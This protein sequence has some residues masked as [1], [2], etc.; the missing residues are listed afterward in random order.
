MSL[1]SI[2]VRLS[3][4][5][6]DFDTDTKRAAN[7]AEKRAKEI[8]A[9]FK[10]LGKQIGIALG[11]AI[12]AAAAGTVYALNGAIQKMDETYNAAKKV[13]DSTENFSRLNYAAGLADVGMDQLVTTMG[14]LT[15]SQAAALDTTSEQAK[16]FEALGIKVVDTSGKLRGSTDVMLDFANKFAEMKGSPEA[17][18]AGF[19]L[20]GRS[21]QD[22]IPL[23]EQGSDEIR[24]LMMEAD[25]L[26]VTVSDKTGAA[27]DQF[28][29][30]LDK[31]Q[32][33][34]GGVWKEVAVGLLPNLDTAAQRLTT[35]AS[36]GDLAR[37][38]TTLL[39]AALNFG[40]GALERYNLAV[41]NLS[42][43]IE[44]LAGIA[45]GA[46]T[47]I[48]SGFAGLSG[49]LAGLP[50]G[51]AG[52]SD[53]FGQIKD[54]YKKQ[55]DDRQLRAA[56]MTRQQYNDNFM[57]QF[58][59]GIPGV[60]KSI[61]PELPF[62]FA[63]YGAKPSAATDPSKAVRDLMGA[64]SGGSKSGGKSKA[65][66]LTDEQKAAKALNEEYTRTAEGLRERLGLMGLE[67]EAAKMKWETEEGSFKALDPLRKAELIAQAALVDAKQLALDKAKEEADAQK[68]AEEGYLRAI[69]GIDRER[70]TLGMTNEQLEIY[71][72][73]KWAGVEGN[74]AFTDSITAEMKELQKVRKSMDLQVEA[75]DAVR[76][77][78]AN[79]IEDMANGV[80]PIDAFKDALDGL[81]Q[82]LQQMIAD[83]LME[84]FFGQKGSASTG[85]AGGGVW[86]MLGGLFGSFLGGGGGYSYSSAGVTGSE[87]ASA[88]EGFMGGGG[89]ARGGWTGPGGM[90]EV[91]GTV[92][93][94]EV[95]W[96]KGDV[97]RA[98]GVGAVESMRRG[99][100]GRGGVTINQTITVPA[101][102]SYDTAQQ[103]G[104]L[105]YAGAGRAARRNG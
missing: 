69:E 20:F 33:A 26:G 9:T 80:K 105:A 47:I 16:M 28:R 74:Q 84:K 51:L 59:V 64:P 96:S 88:F 19:A 71:N 102:T 98:G 65:A 89:W 97:A 7:I 39:S 86:D 31:L 18:A 56:G 95:V 23:L 8:D 36:D 94:G 27:A 2:L 57:Q 38:A 87:F 72:A 77:A 6:A 4:N 99:R 82:Q 67:T 43:D 68:A 40:V 73:L 83:N 37:N 66:E 49:G 50:G 3:M 58:N 93:R 25:A 54:A 11:T 30:Q 29:D 75:M 24:R 45:D 32:G 10:K 1:G 62:N 17:M 42:I 46:M 48:S 103:A 90:N 15:K 52:I 70:E 14:K 21:F 5:T 53:G 41:D 44:A 79:F 12:S 34:I 81:A 22:M 61:F 85:S 78:G 100:G 91:A 60:N 92:H 13:G 63:T 55:L 76:D 101:N 35:L 104:Q